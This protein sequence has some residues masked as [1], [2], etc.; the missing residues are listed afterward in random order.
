MEELKQKTMNIW[1]VVVAIQSVNQSIE[2]LARASMTICD[3]R[4]LVE[5][6]ICFIYTYQI[7]VLHFINTHLQ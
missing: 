2:W 6:V 7:R 1:F 3:P 5:F 4:D